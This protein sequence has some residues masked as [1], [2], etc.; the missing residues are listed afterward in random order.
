MQDNASKMK[1]GAIKSL[2][3]DLDGTLIDTS[4]GIVEAT[5]FALCAIGD[6]P[7]RADE[8]TPFIGFP[9]ELMFAHFSSK[10]YEDFFRNFQIRGI[11]SIAESAIA[12]DGADM[13]LH[14]AYE[15]GFK[16]GIGT[17]KMRIHI[18]RI[19]QK[20]G[21]KDIISVYAGA[22]DVKH[23]KPDPEVYLKIMELL[24]GSRQDSLVIGDTINDVL[25]AHAAGLPVVAV[26]SPFGDNIKL[27]ESQP[28]IL[29]DNIAGLLP[30]L[31]LPPLREPEK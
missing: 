15:N 14:R 11:V 7:R 20:L 5:N 16:I 6:T 12:L 17:H 29:I 19:I 22:D 13:V 10:S 9:L 31:G 18:D 26:K 4:S 25:A 2:L 3:F 1:F 27:A 8:I 24:G 28:D 30:L 23:G 21:W